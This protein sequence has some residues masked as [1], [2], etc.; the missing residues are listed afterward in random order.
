MRSYTSNQIKLNQPNKVLSVSVSAING[1]EYWPYANSSTDP[2][3]AS[4]TS[5][6]YY[7]WEIT[8]SVTEVNH[9]SN[10]T[11]DDFKFN[12]LDIVVGDW[13]AGAADGKCL[14][15]ISISAKTKTSVTCVV[16]DWLRYNTF[17]ASNG[18]GIFNTGNAIVFSLNENGDP[19][20]DPVP[21]TVSNTFFA[22]ISSRF[23]YLNPQTNYV[24]H[25]TNHGFNKG[26]VISVST[27]GYVKSNAETASSMVGVV[28]ESGPGPDYFMIL[29]NNRIIDFDPAITG[30]QGERIYVDVDGTLSN[31]ATITKK[32]AFIVLESAI[33][34]VLTGTNSDPTIISGYQTLINGTLMTFT[35]AGG[36]VNVSEM[37]NIIN[38]ES[39][40]TF[41]VA[42]TIPEPTVVSSSSTGTA[43][44]LVG[45]YVPF[46]A[47]INDVTVNFTTSGSQYAGIS[48]PEDMAIDINNAG[49][50]NLTASASST[51]LTLTESNGANIEISNVTN[52]VNNNPFVGTSNVSGLPALTVGSTGNLLQ[53]TRAD[54]GEILIYES[55]DVFQNATGIFSGQNGSLPL[56]INIEQGVRTSGGTTV[57]ADISARDALYSVT[58][59]QAYV[60]DTGLGEWGLY[61]YNGSNWIQV[62]NHDSSTVDARTLITTFNAPIAGG[63]SSSVQN[64][65]SI[66]PGRKITTVSVE[67]TNPFTG[68][69]Q[70]ATIEVG[71]SSNPDQFFTVTDSDLVTQEEFIILPEYVHAATE[72]SELMVQARLNHFSAT[73]GTV[74]VKVT[75]L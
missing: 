64:M 40:N 3:Y 17:K 69:S 43:Y 71:T 53:L 46:S 61:L 45:G 35:G 33:P 50:A 42:E 24:L 21:S 1:T 34:T 59:D 57:V 65:G 56:A 18:N 2:W 30:N 44:G 75:Y 36:L 58:G 9:G 10:L 25:K 54:G 37:S 47:N 7:R 11:R 14:K 52:D 51:V 39:A 5:P 62:A 31:V 6:R 13:I 68:G 72:V 28:T 66:S 63:S 70:E 73:Q 27:S 74:T 23:K 67:V 55:S 19:M 48:T 22:T 41:V 29:P 15:I 20:I 12:G 8:F 26:D 49:I 32:V 4:G 60:I 38:A 16:E